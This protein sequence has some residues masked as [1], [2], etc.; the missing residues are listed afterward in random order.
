MKLIVFL[1]AAVSLIAQKAVDD[2]AARHPELTM[3]EVAA[4]P[5]D[6]GECRTIASTL[7]REIGRKC[8]GDELA[9]MKSDKVAVD[10]EKE[11]FDA[12]VPLH[13]G[14]RAVIAVVNMTF[15]PAPGQ[16]RATVMTQA[17][18][19]VAELETRLKSRRQLFESAR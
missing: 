11:G 5:S 3:L 18:Q 7:A 2:V 6:T 10:K 16:S 8:D 4:A 9:L 13:D 19:I 17:Q 15:K 14:S 1:L 12:T